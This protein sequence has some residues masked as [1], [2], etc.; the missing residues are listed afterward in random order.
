MDPATNTYT[1]VSTLSN[2]Y[3]VS[4]G[5]TVF[6]GLQL[7]NNTRSSKISKLRGEEAQRQVEDAIAQETMQA[8]YNLAY[9]LGTERLAREQV[10]ASRENLH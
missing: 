7:L 4:A 1:S 5:I 10:E 3:S 8:Y 6:N 9:A 2:S